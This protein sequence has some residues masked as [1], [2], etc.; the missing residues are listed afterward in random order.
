MKIII[1]DVN[2]ADEAAFEELKA[3]LN[4]NHWV[5]KLHTEV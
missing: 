5:W 4:K 2:L 3:W 1:P